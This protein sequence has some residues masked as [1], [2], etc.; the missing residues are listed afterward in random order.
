MRLQDRICFSPFT[1]IFIFLPINTTI[2]HQA[3]IYFK[4]RVFRSYPYVVFSLPHCPKRLVAG[5]LSLFFKSFHLAINRTLNSC[6]ANVSRSCRVFIASS[7]NSFDNLPPTPNESSY[8]CNI[9]EK[10][11]I[12]KSL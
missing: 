3:K 9:Y 12:S 7:L 8:F 1:I 6:I 11:E 4:S 10:K 5:I 2:L